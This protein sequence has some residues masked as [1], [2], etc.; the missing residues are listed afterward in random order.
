M[1][2]PFNVAGELYHAWQR[3]F[4]IL[5]ISWN[6]I[7]ITP[8]NTRIGYWMLFQ[9]GESF[10]LDTMGLTFSI[11]TEEGLNHLVP[12]LQQPSSDFC[13]FVALCMNLLCPKH[14][15][16]LKWKSWI[17]VHSDCWQ[18]SA[19]GLQLIGLTV[20]RVCHIFQRTNARNTWGWLL[21]L[22]AFQSPLTNYRNHPASQPAFRFPSKHLSHLWLDPCCLDTVHAVVIGPYPNQ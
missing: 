10:Y 20:I 22:N 2:T 7:Q 8:A 3:T 16:T 11:W 9:R 6:W 21:R 19:S 5:L 14:K 1:D 13:F 12:F 15:W 17:C 18:H 4:W